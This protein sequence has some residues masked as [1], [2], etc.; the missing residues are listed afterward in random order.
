[1]TNPLRIFSHVPSAHLEPVRRAH[2]D[3]EI[4]EIPGKGPIEGDLRAEIL[5]TQPWAS[6]NL[7][8]IM[9]RGVRWVHAFGTGVD[10]FP[11]PLLGKAIL[12]CS[13]GASATAISEWVL[14][15]MLA[16]EKRL[17]ES[18]IDEP[19]ARWSMASL[20]S[21]ADKKLG[22]IGFG[23]IAQAIARR[24][25]PFGMRIAALR[26]TNTK[27]AVEGVAIVESLETLLAEADHVVV[28]APLTPATHHLLGTQAFE[29]MKPGVHL[30]NISRGGLVDHD[31][32][33]NALGDDG[34]SLASLDCVEPEPVPE[35]HWLYSHPRVRLSAHVSWNAPAAYDGLIDPFV[36]NLGRY[37]RGEELGYRVDP[38]EGY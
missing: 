28:T 19:P 31:A 8:D 5:L 14:A 10:R 6:P 24:A 38:K 1:V 34:V 15:V 22:L 3:V 11:V 26:R 35:G 16:A 13:R 36:E 29:M 12:T 7:A 25:L 37:R 32:L 21:L 33:R 4:V 27:S 20:G 9:A 30:V 23:E 2:P 17:P 18:W